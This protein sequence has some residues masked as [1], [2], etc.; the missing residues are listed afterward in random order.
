MTYLAVLLHQ[1]FLTELGVDLGP[2]EDAPGPGGVVECGEGL[3]HVDGCWRYRGDDGG[4]GPTAQRV[5]EQPGQFGLPVGNVWGSLHQVGDHPAEGQQALV[6]VA[7]FPDMTK[8][9]FGW[10]D[11]DV[12]QLLP[13]STVLGSGLPNILCSGQINQVEL[14]DPQYLRTKIRRDKPE[15][16]PTYLL[17]QGPLLDVNSHREDGVGPAALGVHLGLRSLPLL[18]PLLEDPVDLFLVVD[19]HFFKALRIIII[20]L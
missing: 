20:L 3:L 16:Y 19:L 17:L 18:T 14:S 2:V 11:D 6:D 8:S 1:I 4:L 10:K 15:I 7:S 12:M 5:L 9:G 13:G